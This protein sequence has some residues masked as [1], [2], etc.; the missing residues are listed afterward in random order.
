MSPLELVIYVCIAV[1]ALCWLVSILTKNYSQVDRLWSLIPEVYVGIFAAYAGFANARLNIMFVLT[2]MWGARLTYN[3]ARKGGYDWSGEDYRWPILRERFGPLWFQVFNATFIAPYQNVI[4]L[5]IAL[6][7]WFAFEHQAPLGVIDIVATIAFL[8]F[9]LGET[10]ADEQQWRFHKAKRERTMDPPFL[11]TGLFRFSRH[12]N[13][14]CE[15]ALWWCIAAFG[16]AA[17]GDYRCFVGA[18][19]LVLLFQGSTTFTERISI[20]KYPSYKDYQRTTSRL[21]PMPSKRA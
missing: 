21:L 16:Y 2:V 18:V 13:F 8:S 10:I 6:P 14:F 17:S 5:L 4:L 20:G 9:L 12:P 15:Q 19:M 7:A 3:F 1:T 11:T